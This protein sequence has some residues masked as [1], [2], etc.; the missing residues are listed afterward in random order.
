M[1][2][3]RRDV[4]DEIEVEEDNLSLIGR[5][6]TKAKRLAPLLVGLIVVNVML[7]FSLPYYPL[8]WIVASFFLY[9]YYFIVLLFPTTRR[10]RT[11]AEKKKGVRPKPWSGMGRGVRGVIRRGKKAVVVAFWNSFFIGTQTL[12]RGII[13][14]LAFSIAFAIFN[15]A[16]GVLDTYSVSVITLQAGAIAGY[17][18]VIAHWR[19]YSKDFMRTVA[20]VK[21]A[22][23]AKV[24]WQAYLKGVIVVLVLLT[25]F[26][27]F[28]VT[29]IFF[30]RRSLDAVLDH[31]SAD[32]G[33]VLIGLVVIFSSQFVF[34]RFIQGFDSARV[35]SQ[36]I[37]AK[38]T[39][40][41]GDIL[42]GLKQGERYGE[43]PERAASFRS[44][45]ARFRVSRIYKV[46][47]KDIFGILPTYPII[48][49]FKAILDEDVAEALSEEIPLD[50]PSG[51]PP[52]VRPS[53]EKSDIGHI[54][55]RK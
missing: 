18:Y 47:Y 3:L 1:T 36:F 15:L 23:R 29:A 46:V 41:R 11:P 55:G 27:A 4:L 12:A 20:R 42:A 21:V 34:V 39:F 43:G 2:A 30:P 14:I 33:P 35:T 44:L 50:I 22:R 45:Q 49:D 32:Y 7:F 53:L 37:I 8:Y 38:L 25:V 10:V 28:L 19:P 9:M 13:L 24:R 16:T 31:I 40:L 26:G 52:E 51:S 6:G 48:V 17:Y 5:H 54:P